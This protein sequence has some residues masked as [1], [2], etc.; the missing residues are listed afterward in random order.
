MNAMSLRSTSSRVRA[1]VLAVAALLATA[2]VIAAEVE[3]KDV[4]SQAETE[5]KLE[6]ARWAA[7][8]LETQFLQV[9][10]AGQITNL[11]GLDQGLSL[12]VRP[13]MAARWLR[14]AGEDERSAEPG[15]AAA[16]V[17]ARTPPRREATPRPS[18]TPRGPDRESRHAAGTRRARPSC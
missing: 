7:A 5:R 17:K 18:P 4:E 15:S 1:A 14:T 2:T 11:R 12:D 6:D 8:R 13:F 3:K 10:E 9:S 16:A